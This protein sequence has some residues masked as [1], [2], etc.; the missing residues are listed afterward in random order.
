MRPSFLVSLIAVLL[1]ACQSAAASHV[2]RGREKV[3]A[4][5]GGIGLVSPPRT[6]EDIVAVLDSEKPDPAKYSQYVARGFQRIVPARMPK[7]TLVQGP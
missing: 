4:N 5:F 6:I 1:A 7:R 3:T 2:R